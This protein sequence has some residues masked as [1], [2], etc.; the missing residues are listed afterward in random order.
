[1]RSRAICIIIFAAQLI[2]L[3]LDELGSK[4]CTQTWSIEQ[5]NFL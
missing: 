4:Q 3:S 2:K 5:A 1:M